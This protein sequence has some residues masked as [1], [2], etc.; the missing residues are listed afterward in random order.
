MD[1][2]FSQ[3]QQLIA[4]PSPS[5][6]TAEV[7]GYV[8]EELRSLGF[9][10]VLTRKGCVVCCLGGEGRPLVY[11][12]HIDT[13]GAVVAEVKANGQLRL[14]PIGGLAAPN[15]ETENC[16]I[17]TRSGKT[18]TGTMQLIDPSLHVNPDFKTKERNYSTM[19]V[20]LDAK[21]ASKA[22][23]RA[24][25]IG[26]G[27]LVAFDPRYT[28]TDTG[29]IKSR[30]LDDKLSVAILLDYAKAVREKRASLGR[31]V[32][33]FI[34]VYEE[35]GH[36]AASG[37]PQDAEEIV[38]VDMGCV[39]EGLSCTEH[40]V[41]ICVKDSRGPYNRAVT[42][43]LMDCADRCGIDYEADVYPMYGS[44]ADAALQAGWELRHGLIGAGVYA[45]HGYERTHTDGVKQTAALVRAYA[46]Q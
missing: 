12:A 24:L 36:G 33:L 31:R 18:Y 14:S 6:F 15:I 37:L 39:G 13:L 34:S 44:D 19:Q 42:A 23:T 25:G 26:V 7:A 16:R 8:M 11:A 32:Y 40:Q 30:F 2:L 43:A 27:D 46:E 4:I 9:D 10:P 29:Y 3:L 45:S 35:V 21:T 38:S 17:F 1:Y 20:V 22:E 41:S 28:V 5:G